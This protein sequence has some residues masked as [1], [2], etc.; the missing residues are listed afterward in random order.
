MASGSETQ[1]IDVR[2]PVEWS[3]DESKIREVVAEAMGCSEER[4]GKYRV[5][6]K[7]LDARKRQVM[8]VWR[9]EVANGK[10]DLP[11]NRFLRVI[12]S[13]FRTMRSPSSSLVQGLQA[14]LLHYR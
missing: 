3:G 2:F 10:D 14:C 1:F 8:A 4:L 12:L 9:I 6:R 13:P 7:N 5:V 11:E